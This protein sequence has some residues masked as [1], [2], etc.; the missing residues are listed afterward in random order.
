MAWADIAPSEWFVAAIVRRL[1]G[2]GLKVLIRTSHAGAASKRATLW[3]RD[4]RV[5]AI[6]GVLDGLEVRS[7]DD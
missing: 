3:T 5:S 7:V 4:R 1:R 2:R 6:A